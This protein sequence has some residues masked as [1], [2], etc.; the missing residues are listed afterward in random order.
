M[1]GIARKADPPSG[2]NIPERVKNSTPIS[3]PRHL[4]KTGRGVTVNNW[5]R[6]CE[7][8]NDDHVVLQKATIF[9]KNPSTTAVVGLWAGD[10]EHSAQARSA[11]WPEIQRILSGAW[12]ASQIPPA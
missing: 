10:D 7:V 12:N 4:E 2:I 1:V 6:V 9:S 5:V 8:V 3:L 11:W